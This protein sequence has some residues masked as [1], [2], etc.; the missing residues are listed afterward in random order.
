MVDVS[1][2]SL[3]FPESSYSKWDTFLHAK[4]RASSVRSDPNT[5]VDPSIMEITILFI[6]SKKKKKKSKYDITDSEKKNVLDFC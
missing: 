4:D 5:M 2:P 1:F 3:K 6:V